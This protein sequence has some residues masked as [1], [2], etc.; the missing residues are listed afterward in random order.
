M[1]ASYRSELHSFCSKPHNSLFSFSRSSHTTQRS[2]SHATSHPR[3][4]M[5]PALCPSTVL[6]QLFLQPL[7]SRASSPAT[8]PAHMDEP[9]QPF[10]GIPDHRPPAHCTNTTPP[11]PEPSE[12]PS[13]SCVSESFVR[14]AAGRPPSRTSS[15][16]NTPSRPLL[17]RP[18][19][20]SSGT[21][22]DR[23]LHL[24]IGFLLI[25]NPMDMKMLV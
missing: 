12:A 14:N 21:S 10:E 1:P 9:L 4:V 16:S 23:M 15:P 8:T 7:L 13:S 11:S 20:L 18:P 3:T 24:V 5:H 25:L 22:S 6:Q 17:C 2:S 19:S